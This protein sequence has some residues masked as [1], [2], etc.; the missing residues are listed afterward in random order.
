MDT[1]E[2][3][4]GENISLDELGQLLA[5]HWKLLNTPSDRLAIEESNSRVY[6]YH[7]KQESG[8]EDPRRIF[9]E[10]SWTDLIKRVIEVIAD[11]PR[12]LIDNDFG[13]GLPGDQF[14]ARL[15]TDPTWDWRS[16]R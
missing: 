10:Y 14:V 7:P 12:L 9:V 1:I 2:I 8:E 16:R 3:T 4:S 11:N 5:K 6:I 13:T 15:R